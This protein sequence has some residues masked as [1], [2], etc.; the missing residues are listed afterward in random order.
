M[1]KS[2]GLSARGER[3]GKKDKSTKSKKIDFSDIPELSDKQLSRM[4]RGGR[5]T[6]G[7]EPRQLIAIRLDAIVLGWL[8]KTAEKKGLPYQTLVYEI[9]AAEMKKAS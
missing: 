4:P 2:H 9:L 5:P 7:D 3:A 6:G 8:R 1:K